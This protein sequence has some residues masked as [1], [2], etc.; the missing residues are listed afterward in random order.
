M[1]TKSGK[2]HTVHTHLYRASKG[3]KGNEEKWESAR[4]AII[5]YSYTISEVGLVR[6]NGI[7]KK[8]KTQLRTFVS[9]SMAWS[10]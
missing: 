3:V 5:A 9:H 4:I 6:A 8:L 10:H 2:P 7:Y 1:N